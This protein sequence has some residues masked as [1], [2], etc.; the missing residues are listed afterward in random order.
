MANIALVE[1]H[2]LLRRGLA[3]LIKELGNKICFEADNGKECMAMLAANNKPD[4]ILMDINMPVMDGY[5]T[6]LF[7][8]NTYPAVKVLALS[9]YD[10]ETAVIRMLKNGARGYILKNCDPMQLTN[11]IQA[12]MNK[13]YYHS[14]LVSSRLIH[15]INNY[16]DDKSGLKKMFSLNARE[17]DFLKLTATELTYKEMAS[18]MHVSFRTVDG[19]REALFLKLNIKSRVGLVIYAI[20][21]GI[22]IL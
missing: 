8:K 3:V 15:A 5:E 12:V 14:D 4:I 20:K 7:V 1:D 9:M 17:V 6:A 18:K 21:N 16:D 13:G 19:Y 11:A 10:D 22:V 2:V